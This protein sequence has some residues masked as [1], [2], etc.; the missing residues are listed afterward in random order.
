MKLIKSGI[1][2]ILLMI[3][4]MILVSCNTGKTCQGMQYHNNDV[5]RGLAH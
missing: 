4:T 5:K 1:F 2:I 3:F